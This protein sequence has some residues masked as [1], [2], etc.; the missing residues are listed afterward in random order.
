MLVLNGKFEQK[1]TT[2]IARIPGLSH[3]FHLHGH[4]FYVMG[5]GWAEDYNITGFNTRNAMA[6]DNQ[7]KI[8]RNLKRPLAK[9]TFA[10]PNNGYSI[11]RFL[12]N[13]PGE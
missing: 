2:L 6:L 12:A 13:N 7:G 5:E 10:V 9:D 8:K 11:I 3:P 4:P 1:L